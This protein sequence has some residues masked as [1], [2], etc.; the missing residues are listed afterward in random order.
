MNNL[1]YGVIGNCKSAA[2]ILKNGSIDWFCV[3]KF[4]SPSM[5]AR[6]LD[7]KKGGS[8]GIDVKDLKTTSQR[9]EFRTNILITTFVSETGV[10]EIH[11]FMPRYLSESGEIYNPCDIVRYIRLVSGVCSIRVNFD[12]RMEYAHPQTHVDVRTDYIKAFTI[13]KEYESVY[14]YT[15]LPKQ[16]VVNGNW[17]DINED[18]FM[19]LCYNQKLLRQ[20]IQRTNLKLQRTKVYWL[21]WAERTTRYKFFTEEIIRSALVLKM[22]SYDKTGAILAAL[23]TSLPETVGEE[24]NWDYRFCWIRDA[25]MVIRIM[26]QLGHVKM[27]QK[28]LRYIIGLLPEKGHKMQIMYGIDG[29]RKLT[30]KT[31][32]HLSG[33]A[34]SRP[35]RVGNAAYHQK[36][37][38]IYGILMDVIHQHF[39]LYTTTLEFG[40]DLWTVV[41]SIMRTVSK[42]WQKPDRGIWELRNENRHFVFSKVLCWMAADRA[43]KIAEILNQPRYIERWTLLR[44]EIRNDILRNGWSESRQSFTQAYGFEDMDAS[45]LLMETYG[46]LPASDERFRKTVEAIAEDLSNN[47]LLYRYKNK[48]D[49][50]L[51]QSAFT[52]CTFW[53]INALFKIGKHDDARRRFVQLLKSGN[54]LGLFSEDLD[55]KTRRLLGNFPQ[56]YSH[57]ALIETAVTVSGIE[58]GEDEKILSSLM[59]DETTSLSHAQTGV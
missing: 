1:H 23:T 54:H 8:W 6:I 11:D 34:N 38:D 58:M 27:A 7:E 3:P 41:R 42:N 14:L 51:P 59:S 28:Y 37:N 40:E 30:E 56:A 50:G 57:L 26:S 10:I 39:K 36:Q 46:F 17:I 31:L 24:R 2:L 13:G 32:S 21:N 35:V 4:D 22:L 45:L 49:F 5:F 55:F 25:S 43:V 53:L 18:R 15:D 19:L 16:D 52:I 47:G 33:Y 12:P 29:E 9:Y 48:D 20:D 44:E